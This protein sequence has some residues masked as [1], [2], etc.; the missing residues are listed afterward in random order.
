MLEPTRQAPIATEKPFASLAER[1]LL[2]VSGKGGVGR[3]TVAALLA[4]ALADGRRR[5]LV[6]TTGHDDRLAWMLGAE[7]LS[8]QARELAPGLF[9]QRLTPSVCVR[10]YGG[11]VA[12]QRVA[13]ERCVRESPGQG[14]AGG[15]AGPG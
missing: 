2:I 4:S 9:A 5:I 1:S 12:A 10:E 3:T 14:P 15:G 13:G 6:A 11:L 7:S 8:D